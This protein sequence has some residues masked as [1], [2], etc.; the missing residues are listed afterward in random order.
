L[1]NQGDMRKGKKEITTNVI[2]LYEV[3]VD[4]NKGMHLGI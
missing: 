4:M 2:M 3:H 1:K